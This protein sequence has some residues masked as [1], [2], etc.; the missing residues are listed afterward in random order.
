MIYSLIMGFRD[1]VANIKKTVKTPS[2]NVDTD[3]GTVRFK[4]TIRRQGKM[5]VGVCTYEVYTANSKQEA[6]RFLRS[7]PV[8]KDYY[9][10]EVETPEGDVGRD[11][12]EIY[13]M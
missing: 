8:T 11:K 6:L 1:I 12:F 9:F 2:G 3:S 13:Q 10:I 4:E 7:K 5:G